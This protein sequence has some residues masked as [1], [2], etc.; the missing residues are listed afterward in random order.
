M[1]FQVLLA[2]RGAVVIN[3]TPAPLLPLSPAAVRGRPSAVGRRSD[4]IRPEQP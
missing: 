1:I 2:L 4:T 3:F